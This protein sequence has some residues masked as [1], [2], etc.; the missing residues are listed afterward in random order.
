MRERGRER[1]KEGERERGR[2]RKRARETESERERERER[3][4]AREKESERERVRERTCV[5]RVN[6]AAFV[7]NSRHEKCR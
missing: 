1:T 6:N 7:E 2:E 4:R 5:Q 3:K